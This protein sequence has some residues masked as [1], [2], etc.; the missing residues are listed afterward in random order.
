MCISY[1]LHRGLVVIPKTVNPT[2]IVENFKS[3]TLSLT[4]EDMSRLA[5]IDKNLRLM[6]VM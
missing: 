2:R 3:V 4:E 1:G 6:K 5:G